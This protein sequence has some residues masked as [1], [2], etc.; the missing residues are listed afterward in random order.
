LCRAIWKIFAPKIEANKINGL[1]DAE[2]TREISAHDRSWRMAD[3]SQSTVSAVES[4][5][6]R[7]D[8]PVSPDSI[9]RH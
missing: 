6:L 1:G 4:H 8:R 9:S 5:G 7:D 2:V 3:V